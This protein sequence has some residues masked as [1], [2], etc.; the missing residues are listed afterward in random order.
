MITDW[1]KE[2]LFKKITSI[3][4]VYYHIDQTK[5]QKKNN[6]EK[7]Q[8]GPSGHPASPQKKQTDPFFSYTRSSPLLSYSPSRSFLMQAK[9]QPLLLFFFLLSTA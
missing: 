3:R 9:D 2:N 6:L 8:V 4:F 5:L 7:I 1:R